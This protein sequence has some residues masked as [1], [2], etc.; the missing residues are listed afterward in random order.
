MKCTSNVVSSRSYLDR[1]D[2]VTIHNRFADQFGP[3]NID[4]PVQNDDKTP[5]STV[6]TT[7]ELACFRAGY[8]HMVL[9]Q[10]RS[11]T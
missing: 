11:G 10:I 8:F 2:V 9:V 5:R 1:T 7:M 3:I 6:C 4:Q